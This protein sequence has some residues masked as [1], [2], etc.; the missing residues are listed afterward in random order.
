MGTVPSFRKSQK[1]HLAVA[2]DFLTQFKDERSSLLQQV[3]MGDKMWVYHYT[4]KSNQQS[5]TW[6][7]KGNAGPKKTKTV[8]LA[9]KLMG[10]VFWHAAGLLLV[11]YVPKGMIISADIYCD[12]LHKL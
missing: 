12:I 11:W 7:K 8:S 9:G 5:K 3:V 4:P 10:T 2:L 6:V 1:N